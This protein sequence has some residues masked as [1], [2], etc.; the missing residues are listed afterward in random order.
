VAINIPSTPVPAVFVYGNNHAAARNIPDFSLNSTSNGAAV[1]GIVAVYLTGAG[2]VQGQNLLGTGQQ[3]PVA[4]LFPVTADFSATI[5][6]VAAAV[7]AIDLVPTTVGGFYQANIVI[8][9][10]ASG[11]RNMVITIGGK[12]SNTTVISVK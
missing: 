5:A 6:G 12:A 10:V 4:P 8:P 7:Q 9:K 3:T 1:G 11:D 2:A